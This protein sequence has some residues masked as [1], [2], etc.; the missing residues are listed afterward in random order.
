[1]GLTATWRS[2]RTFTCPGRGCLRSYYRRSQYQWRTAGGVR[3]AGAAGTGAFAIVGVSRFDAHRCT[4][5]AS[6]LLRVRYR[7]ARVGG[8]FGHQHSQSFEFRRVGYEF[9]GFAALFPPQAYT[10]MKTVCTCGFEYG[11]FVARH[12]IPAGARFNCPRCDSELRAE[13]TLPAGEPPPPRT[14]SALEG[15]SGVR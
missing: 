5:G 2:N 10:S 1:M 15:D 13:A 6:Y 14:V 9:C 8:S 3:A 7:V 11:D 4:G 12:Q